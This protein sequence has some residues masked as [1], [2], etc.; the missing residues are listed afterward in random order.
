MRL[1][2]W[3]WVYAL[4]IY[5]Y[6][7]CVLIGLIFLHICIHIYSLCGSIGLCCKRKKRSENM[8]YLHVLPTHHACSQSHR[9]NILWQPRP[10]SIVCPSDTQHTHRLANH[11]Q[12]RVNYVSKCASAVWFNGFGGRP[13]AS[14]ICGKY[15]KFRL[16]TVKLSANFYFQI[17]T[18]FLQRQN[19]FLNG[20]SSL[21]K[22]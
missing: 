14:F 11:I 12:S 6:I 8:A 17:K 15:K 5:T 3:V 1:L 10:S 22:V 18:K 13:F 21:I 7:L 20:I 16:N 19:W 2:S 9:D 4:Y